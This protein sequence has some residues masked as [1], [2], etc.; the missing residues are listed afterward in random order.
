[1]LKTN[2]KSILKIT[3]GLAVF[4]I[5]F[6]SCK[7]DKNDMGDI[8]GP[9]VNFYAL[10]SDSKLLYVNASKPSETKAS[11]NI[12][13]LQSGETLLGVDFRPATGQLYGVGSTSRIY[14]IDTKTGAARAIGTS[15]FTPALNGNVVGFDF[16]PTVDRIRL[17]TANGQNLRLNPE[18]GA[19]QVTDGAIN[20]AAN[21]RVA[22]AAYTNSKAGAATTV[23][24]DIDVA[25]N[26]L[27]KQDPPNNGTLVEVGDL[28]IDAEDN[29]GFDISPDNPSALAALS[30]AGK[31]NLYT[32]D[33]A[34]GKAVKVG[35]FSS[36]I[37]GLA[38]PT[39]AV[40]YAVNLSNELLIFNPVK[41]AT[42]VAKIIMGMQP[43]ENVIGIDFRPVNGQLYAAGSTGR[44][45]TLNTS[46]GAAAMVGV[47]PFTVLNGTSFGFDFNP[48]VDRIRLVSDK[49]QNLRLNPNDGLLAATDGNLNPSS[50]MVTGAAYTN[51]FAGATTTTLYDIDTQ[52]NKIF[53]Q[54]PPNMGTLVEVGPISFDVDV[55]DGFDIGGTSGTAYAILSANSGAKIYTINLQTG[56]A[57]VVADFPAQVRGFALG[58]GF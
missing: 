53:K 26:K 5:G 29:G 12:T 40:A 6:V 23:L 1:M 38:I 32:I 58:L 49:G 8:K 44:L 9:D 45:Y 11:V 39:E 55:N 20:G 50:P 16:N 56:A 43:G 25:N 35:E 28:G 13:G 10:T 34:T 3:L 14:V 48:T 27:Y 18:T 19:V 33:I 21:A 7:K 2:S 57:T 24:Y 51:N 15:A 37:T 4:S 22:S 31:S 17:V 36:A 46:S 41:P 52:S 54:D 47:A 42:P 30:V